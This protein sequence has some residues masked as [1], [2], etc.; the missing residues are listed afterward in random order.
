M[1]PGT[2]G[3]HHVTSIVGDAQRNVDFYAGVLGLR[4]VKRTVNFEDIL[5]YHLYYG[6]TTG[7]PGTVVTAFPS[8]E[9]DPGRVG[10]PQPSAAAF[11]IPPDSVDRWEQYL[12]R[13]GVDVIRGERFDEPVLA[14]SDPDGT[15]LELVATESSVEP[16]TEGSIPEDYAIRGL[17]GVTVLPT[18]PYGA[19]TVLETI[20]F[21]LAAEAEDVVRYEVADP[22]TDDTGA[23]VVDID[24]SA[25][26][27]GR[28]GT[29]THHHVA[30][31]MP[32]EDALHEWRAVFDDRGYTVSRVKDRHFFH[33]LYVRG[34]GGI[35]VELATTSP[36][37]TAGEDVATLGESLTLPDW[38]EEDRDLIESQLPELDLPD[39][40]QPTVAAFPAQ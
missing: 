25:A 17:H 23:S 6:N 34:P 38:F 4:L 37:I 3:L 2:T 1:P 24:L 18:D 5:Q 26:E 29:G 20:G 22:S 7:E 35:L 15:P 21:E 36:G 19:A 16:W 33:S 31:T 27:Y 14:F 30:V 9:A 8:P 39:P 40:D 32:D 28:E 13:A 10:K 12:E 11:A